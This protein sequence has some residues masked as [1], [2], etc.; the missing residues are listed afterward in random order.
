MS[1]RMLKTLVAVGE[2]GTFCAAAD[3][4]FV[5]HAA[6]SQ[7][8]K[9]LEEE[10]QVTIFDRS[11][12]SP[13]FT[14]IGRAL[15]VK[16]QEVVRAYDNILPSIIGDDGLKG[17]FRLGAVP[18]TLNGLV[19][20]SIAGLKASFP[21]L[22]IGLFPDLTTSLIMQIKRGTLD[23]AIV[24][25]P[26]VMPAEMGW[27]EIAEENLELIASKE[28]IG[29]DPVHLLKNAPFIRFS[30]DAVV[31]RL[32]EAWLQESTIAVT[33]SMELEGLEA[34]SSMVMSNLG[35]SIVPVRCVRAQNALQLKHLPLPQSA[36]VRQLGLIYRLD[37]TK[38]RVIE[39]VHKALLE[40][41]QIGVF[42]A[43]EKE[44]R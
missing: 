42:P 21:D 16:A 32:I 29:D 30:R 9:A 13:S 36:P 22:H 28:T 39:E 2:H 7:Q 18:T 17:D 24:T 4:V 15:L 35:V 38:P 1:I 25:K 5:S 12:R 27:M 40:A 34:I 43:D 37:N 3:A 10:W 14:P 6:V 41:V 23:A 31:G 11:N 19:P 26:N 20:A 8:M 33:E 44:G